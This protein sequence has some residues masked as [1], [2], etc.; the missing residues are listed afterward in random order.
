MNRMNVCA[1]I[2]KKFDD[3]ARPS[4]NSAVERRA[5]GAIP[6]IQETEVSIEKLA[7][8]ANVAGL[9]R[10][11]DLMII[12]RCRRRRS[13]A[14]ITS[15]LQ[16]NR[17]GFM[18]ALAGHFNQTETIMAVPFR[19][20]AGIEK[21]PYNVE[22]SFANRKV[23]GR[24]VEIAFSAAARIDR[25]QMAHSGDVAAI[26]SGDDVPGNV[27]DVGR[28]NHFA[29]MYYTLQTPC[30]RAR[31][32]SP[33]LCG[34]VLESLKR[35]RVVAKNLFVPAIVI[36][37]LVS[38]A[39]PVS[40][41][42]SWP[43]SYS[44]L[45]TVKGTVIEFMWANPHPMITLEVRTNDGGVEKWLIGGPATNRMEANGWT[46]TTVKP[47]DVITGIGYQF[48]DGQK[49]VRLERAILADGKEIRV[50]GR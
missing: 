38:A 13:T 39:V 12:A 48:A 34:S 29:R 11:M 30:F 22:M 14:A 2:E 4:N 27:V 42:H 1:T 10:S 25:E 18:A 16:Q 7:H 15:L 24:R 23:N 36:L 5:A 47:G 44:Q 8:T 43:V 19:I 33:V 46:K 50:Y 17:N 28:L 45:V 6:S 31:M 20:G 41:H 35:R 3:P 32:I 40:A 49:I 37:A 9:G 21:N 26:C